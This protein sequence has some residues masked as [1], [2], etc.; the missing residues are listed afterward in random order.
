MKP[1][2]FV[3]LKKA[4]PLFEQYLNG[5]VE[6]GYRP[7]P[8][9]TLNLGSPEESVTFELRNLS[10]IKRP[11]AFKFISYFIKLPSFTL[12]LM[13]LF[14]VLTKNFVADRFYDPFSMLL[15]SIAIVF[16]YAGLNIRNDVVDHLSGFDRVNIAYSPKPIL[17]GWTTAAASLKISW[18][19]IGI[20]FVISLPIFILQNELIRILAVVVILFLATQFLQKNSYK[21]NWLG[22][23][24]L[25]ILVG[26]ALVAGYQVSLGAGVDTQGLAFGVLWGFACLFLIHVNN[27]SHLL[28]SSQ[29]QIKNSI[30]KMGF[31]RAKTFLMIWWGTAIVFWTIFHWFYSNSFWT[32]FGTAFMIIASMPFFKNLSKIQSPLSSSL[33]KVRKDS[34]RAFLAMVFIFLI[35]N[36]SYVG[37]KLD[38]KI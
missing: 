5:Q 6:P 12:I 18:I 24:T 25:F 1:H 33:K 17:C 15:A 13:P 3:S 36:F 37:A 35:E 28:T 22:E 34:V 31:D 23:W 38:W 26:P 14:F 20:S 30:T 2:R 9:E 4:D 32:G 19:L 29:A 7:I 21:Q 16:L 10:E 11:Q 8:V 27:F